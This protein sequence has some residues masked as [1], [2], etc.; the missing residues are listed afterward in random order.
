M[1]VAIDFDA[2]K[3]AGQ[4][5]MVRP[6]ARGQLV[7]TTAP[8]R[9]VELS[10]VVLTGDPALR[11][12]FV[13]AAELVGWDAS[14][15]PVSAAAFDATARRDHRLVVVD[16]VSPPDHDRGAIESLTRQLASRPDTLVVVCGEAGNQAQEVWARS[17][18]AF[19]F[20]P[21]VTAG[22]PLLTVFRE[23]R[24]VSER[25]HAPAVATTVPSTAR[26][27]CVRG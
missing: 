10:C 26:M 24:T 3:C 19:V 8:E 16:L 17:L 12:R 9:H 13:A 15:S 11:R 22:D 23:A 14:E 18:G 27:A 20:V 2:V 1:A 7:G 4:P 21:G 5:T 25:R 6:F